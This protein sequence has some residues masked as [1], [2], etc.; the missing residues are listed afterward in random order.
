[1]EEV[2]EHQRLAGLQLRQAQEHPE[3]RAEQEPHLP[4]QA[5]L[6]LMQGV[7]VALPLMEPLA[8]VGQVVAV[9]VE[10]L[11]LL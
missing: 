4:F 7:A 6:Q 2:V 5:L 10:D 9:L 8:L 1:V 3:E 11:L